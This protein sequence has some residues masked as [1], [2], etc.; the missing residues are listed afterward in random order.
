MAVGDLD[1]IRSALEQEDPALEPAVARIRALFHS[2][3]EGS[4][5]VLRLLERERTQDQNTAPDE[6]ERCRRLFDASVGDDPEASVALYSFGN[7]ELLD[8]ATVE[9]VDLLDRLG[10]LEDGP[11]VLEIGCGIG[12]F[13]EALAQRVTAITGIDIAPAMVATARRRCAGLPNVRLMKTSGR[14]LALFGSGSFD[15][16]LAIDA[17]PYLYRVGPDLVATHF[18]EVARVLRDGGDFLILNLSYAGDLGRDRQ[19]VRRFAG[20]AGLEVLRNGSADL[21]LWDARTF[22]L[23]RP[24]PARRDQ[25]A[26]RTMRP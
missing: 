24:G 3:L 6:L 21:R 25:P 20:E 10:L 1:G 19:D 4:A 26:R 5:A 22:H 7:R 2:N 23:C 14:D 11:E 18:R 17:M 8:A 13:Q 12:R 16:V 9:V 15:L